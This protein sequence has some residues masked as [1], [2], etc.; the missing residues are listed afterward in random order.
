VNGVPHQAPWVS[1]HAPLLVHFLRMSGQKA[2]GHTRRLRNKAVG[3][4]LHGPDWPARGLSSPATPAAGG[5]AGQTAGQVHTSKG[6]LARHGAIASD[7]RRGVW[8]FNG[9]AVRLM[10]PGHDS[11]RRSV[12]SQRKSPS[13]HAPKKMR[14]GFGGQIL[15]GRWHWGIFA[16]LIDW[17]FQYAPKEDGRRPR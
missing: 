15:F 8:E 4:R 13:P 11:C 6:N 7:C 5:W 1:H 10:P 9:I 14:T 3:R 17:Q 2:N 12:C 16:T